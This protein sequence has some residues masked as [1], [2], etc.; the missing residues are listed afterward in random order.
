MQEL[1]DKFLPT[2]FAQLDGFWPIENKTIN[3][4]KRSDVQLCL[5]QANPHDN[6]R[7]M[8]SYV[9][10]VRKNIAG[11]GRVEELASPPPTRQQVYRN[12]NWL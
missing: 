1:Q 11:Q 8:S 10:N 5:Q 9:D 2:E 6:M 4:S 12:S 7:R 3:F